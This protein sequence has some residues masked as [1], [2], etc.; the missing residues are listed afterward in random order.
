MRKIHDLL[1]TE[2]IVPLR[3]HESAQWLKGLLKLAPNL[4]A[5]QLRLPRSPDLPAM[6]HLRHLILC[7]DDACRLAD[8]SGVFTC[9]HLPSV[10]L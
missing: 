5:L 6:P 9:H 2:L 10:R 3:Q 7:L 4:M 8:N 1:L